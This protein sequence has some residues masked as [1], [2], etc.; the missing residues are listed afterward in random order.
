MA[1]AHS[2][3]HSTWTWEAPVVAQVPEV[4][5]F[6]RL[7]RGFMTAR[8][9]IGVVLL[10]L[11]A[12]IAAIGFAPVQPWQIAFCGA[13]LAVSLAVRLFMK[14]VPPGRTFDRSGSPRSA[15]TSWPSRCCNFLQVANLNYSPLFALPVLTASVLGSMLLAL[16]TAASV[17]LL[18]AG[19]RFAAG[20]GTRRPH[21]AAGAGGAHRRRL[22]RGGAA[23]QPARARLAREDR[24]R[25]AAV[26]GAH[27]GARQRAGDRDAGRRRAGGRRRLAHPRGQP[28]PRA[29]LG[30]Q[31]PRGAGLAAL[32][33]R[34]AGAAGRA[35]AAHLRPRAARRASWRWSSAR[36]A[37][38]PARAHPPDAAAGPYSRDAVRD[39]PA[40]PARGRG[41]LRT[42][43]LA[44]MGRMSAAVAHEIRNPLAAIAQANACWPRTCRARR[45]SS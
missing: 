36:R 4:S 5:A 45:S 7:W 31:A 20:A 43:K 32:V 25:A 8:V 19:R 17:T 6:D 33:S 21:G 27:A 13:Y 41:A 40:G 10:V 9:S 22:L 30:W 38:A 28:A 24:R 34:P 37:P 15:S 44:A 42:E 18:L 29:L 23:G 2:S 16:G 39:V 3:G 14:P 12:G 26:G 1:T 35:G 11:L